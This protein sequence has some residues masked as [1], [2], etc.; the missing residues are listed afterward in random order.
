MNIDYLQKKNRKIF[1]NSL[2]V[3]ILLFEINKPKSKNLT[4]KT[5]KL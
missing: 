2:F 5:T 3:I 4:N 1:V